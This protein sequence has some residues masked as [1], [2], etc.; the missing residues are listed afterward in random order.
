MRYLGPLVFLIA[1]LLVAC[2][3]N[4]EPVYDSRLKCPDCP[5]LKVTRII[6]GDTFDS[7]RGRVRLFGV[8]TPERSQRCYQAATNRLRE[9]AGDVV[10]FQLG[11]RPLDRSGRLL[12]YVYTSAGGSIDEALIREGFGRAWRQDGQ[13]RE[14][15][16][17]EEVI[18]IAKG[19]GCLW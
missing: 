5:L 14:Y 2:S 18:A 7:A 15:L 17:Q 10:R 19:T 9:I 4:N 13:H 16:Y 11:P 6:D 12:Y 1:F 8:D 3:S